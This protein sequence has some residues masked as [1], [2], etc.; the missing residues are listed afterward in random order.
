MNNTSNIL[1]H[2]G[3]LPLGEGESPTARLAAPLADEAAAASFLAR[4][5]ARFSAMLA[6]GRF[7]AF[8]LCLLVFYQVFIALMAFSPPTGGAWGDFVEDFRVRCFQLNPE[9][10]WMRMGSVWLML[11]EPLPLQALV[12]LIWRGPLRDLCRTQRRALLPLSASAMLAV[13]AIAVS[14]LGLGRAQAKPAELPFPADRLRSAL[15]MPAFT[16]LNQD[17]QPVSHADFQG[18]VVLVTAVYSTCTKTCPMM[19][20]KIRLV[21]DQLTPEERKQL[22][23]VAFS[24]N[25]ETDTR[26]L[27][28]RTA[29]LYGMKSPRFHFV[30][31]IPAEVNRLLDQLAVTRERDATTGEITHSNLFFLLDREGR[32]AYRLSLSQKEQSWLLAA[33]RVLLA[34]PP[35]GSGARP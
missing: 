16:L 4:F 17:G 8:T 3:P 24:L 32:I 10:G 29:Q 34:E 21:L 20:T 35:A 25:P 7:P 12:F 13:G 14:L 6:G 28:A 19:L 23:V 2:P 30:N 11:A 18:Q 15:P 22:A 27:R 26:E 9:T 33:L 1:P 5:S 31:G